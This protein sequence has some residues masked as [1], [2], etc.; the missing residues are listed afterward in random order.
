MS[1][2]GERHEEIKMKNEIKKE[3]QK[4]KISVVVPNYNYERFLPETLDSVIAQTYKNWELIVVDDNSTDNSREIVQAYIDKYPQYDIRL[5]HNPRGPNGTPTPVN[6]GIRAMTGEYFAWLSSDDI[7]H[8]EKLEREV[9]FLEQNPH[10]GMVHTAFDIIDDEGKVEKMNFPDYN[11]M[12]RAD[13]WLA[14]LEMN[15]INGN[16]VL[17]RK[18]VFDCVGLFQEKSAISPAIWRVTE[19]LKWYEIA[20]E[21]PVYF[22]NEKLHQARIHRGKDPV[23]LSKI[24]PKLCGYIIEEHL[25]ARGPERLGQK[26]GIKTTEETVWLET[27][28]ALILSK[29]GKT[30]A[31]YRRLEKLRLYDQKSYLK[32]MEHLREADYHDLAAR[33]AHLTI[34]TAKNYR[35]IIKYDIKP[36]YLR[37]HERFQIYAIASA[38]KK[39]GEYEQSLAV[40]RELERHT[41]KNADQY[42]SGAHF[43][44]GE[45]HRERGE[46]RQAEEHLRKC[47]EINPQHGKANQYLKDITGHDH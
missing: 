35:D 25:E 30:D 12:S 36:E 22:I 32:V 26:L 2:A 14:Q 31:Q 28:I 42:Q 1:P 33:H 4:G 16:T 45:I 27:R 41:P 37:Y 19:V 3:I 18:D 44:Q 9:V 6:I 38:L 10:I 21:Y 5:I 11:S 13:F 8:P 47:L 17:C 29:Y 7:F 23:Y 40:F 43:H 34:L 15:R 46:L 20:L 24:A 39:A